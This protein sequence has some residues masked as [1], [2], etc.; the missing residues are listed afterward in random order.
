MV[1]C[2]TSGQELS[3]STCTLL[4]FQSERVVYDAFTSPEFVDRL[5]SFLSLEE[6][7]G[8]DHYDTNRFSMFKVGRG[9]TYHSLVKERP[10]AQECLPRL[11]P[12]LSQFVV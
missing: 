1:S 2:L 11:P 10:P 6:N 4:F 3:H 8:R 5:V 9:I 12:L 7:K